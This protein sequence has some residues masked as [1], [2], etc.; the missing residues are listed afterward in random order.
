LV[1]LILVVDIMLSMKKRIFLNLFIIVAAF[2]GVWYWLSIQKSLNP[3]NNKEVL[4][5]NETISEIT[6]SPVN[7][8]VVKKEEPIV[9]PIEK[10]AVV[11]ST[12]TDTAEVTSLKDAFSKKY[13]KTISSVSTEI[14][15]KSGAYVKGN[16]D[17]DN[18]GAPATFYA[19]NKGDSFV[20]V[21]VENGVVSCASLAGYAF[22][23]SIIPQCYNSSLGTV[24]SR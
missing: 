9:T 8:E 12:S 3:S 1:D 17:F 11:T 23:S 24:V 19:Y 20:I 21:A 6:T 22:P 14:V 4:S 13:G 5:S 18:S 15:S 10:P 16:V 7:M 2:V